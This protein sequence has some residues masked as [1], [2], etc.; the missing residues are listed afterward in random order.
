M[1]SAA[2]IDALERGGDEAAHQVGARAHVGGGDGDGRVLAA[3]VLP[4]VE[5]PDRLH[6]GDDDEEVDDDGDD[7][8]ANEEVGELHEAAASV[9]SCRWAWGRARRG[10]EGVVDGDRRPC[11]A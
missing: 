3:R 5:R 2:A 9:V 4:D 8:S 11:A 6:P 1:P 7:R 10:R